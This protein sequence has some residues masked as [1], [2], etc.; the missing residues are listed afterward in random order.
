ME[1]GPCFVGN[2]SNSTYPNPW[3]W[4]NEVNMLYIDLPNQLGYSYDIATN[5]T[6][7]KLIDGVDEAGVPRIMV[8]DFSEGVPP[9]NNTFVVGTLSSQN[10]SHTTNSAHHIA[11]PLWH[12]A[13][14][15]FE[16]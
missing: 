8:S 11:M 10:R 13:Q 4:N 2:D 7:N 1:N 3:S 14:T 5:C 12:F 6:V 15:W 9:Q 16:E